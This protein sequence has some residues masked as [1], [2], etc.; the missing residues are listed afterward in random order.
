[1]TAHKV[2]AEFEQ[3]LVEL[4]RRADTQLRTRRIAF[5]SL[6]VSAVILLA[7]IVVF[8]VRLPDSV[9][10]VGLFALIWAIAVASSIAFVPIVRKILIE[11]LRR[12]RQ[13]SIIERESYSLRTPVHVLDDRGSDHVH[14]GSRP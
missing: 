14:V 13:T 7:N 9:L 6:L 5:A 2:L 12:P 10:Q 1:M 3:D 8:V 11:T 4:S